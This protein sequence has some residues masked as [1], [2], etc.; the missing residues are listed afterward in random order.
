MVLLMCS[1]T[2]ETRTGGL[3]NHFIPPIIEYNSFKLSFP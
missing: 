3:N 2:T 1:D